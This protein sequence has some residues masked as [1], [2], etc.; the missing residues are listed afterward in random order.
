MRTGIETRA[1]LESIRK[2]ALRLEKADQA[3]VRS[4]DIGESPKSFS[5]FGFLTAMP[6]YGARWYGFVDCID[7]SVIANDAFIMA[8]RDSTPTNANPFEDT[9]NSCGS[10]VSV[11]APRVDL[12]RLR[13]AD[14]PKVC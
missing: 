13:L 6:N 12:L 10:N 8:T 14:M 5:E 1:L 3:G 11:Q 2:R 7:P 9:S 4:R